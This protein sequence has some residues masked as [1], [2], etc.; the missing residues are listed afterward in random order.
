MNLQKLFLTFLGTGLSPNYP[1]ILSKLAALAFGILLINT[2]GMQT[3]FM[4]ILAVAIIG[5]FEINKYEQ[6]MQ[7]HDLPE[8]VID[9]V[10]GVW[11][12][13]LIAVS[14]A[15][16]L[17]YP[18]AQWLAVLLSFA[19]FLLLSQWKPSTIGWIH[20]NIQGGLGTIGDDILAGFAGGFLT[21]VILLGLEKLL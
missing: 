10:A 7:Q 14:A 18:Y 8:V 6:R 21:V 12:A 11:I 2:M 16:S 9:E 3:L 4:I 19:S 15:H 13:L 1:K 20:R 17:T 5:I